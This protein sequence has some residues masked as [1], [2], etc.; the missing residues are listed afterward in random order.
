L[1]VKEDIIKTKEYISGLNFI[2][3]N[4]AFNPAFRKNNFVWDILIFFYALKQNL[5]LLSQI[6]I[7]IF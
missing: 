4:K 5:F 2:E 3:K 7:F 6:L 1:N